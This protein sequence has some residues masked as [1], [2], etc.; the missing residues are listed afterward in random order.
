MV[1]ADIGDNCYVGPEIVAA[2]QLER[3]DFQHVI[4]VLFGCDLQCVAFAYIAPEAY[5]QACIPEQIINKACS[6]GFAVG[7]CYANL[8]G[9]V[10]AGCKFYFGDD[11]AS[12]FS[13]CALRV[14]FRD[15]ALYYLFGIQ[16]LSG[17][18]L[19]L[20][21][22]FHFQT[23][24]LYLSL[25]G[26]KHNPLLLRARRRLLLY[27]NLKTTKSAICLVFNKT[28]FTANIYL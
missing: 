11:T 7:A 20:A 4:I 25:S 23:S 19:L 21:G 18:G 10:V 2:I 17:C 12:L 16:Y 27:K 13:V 6:G 26:E 8:L 14:P 24:Q 22:I 5:I 3:A 15:G 1:R 28:K 9:L